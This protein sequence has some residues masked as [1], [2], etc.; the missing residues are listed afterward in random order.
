M[1]VAGGVHG[2]LDVAMATALEQGQVSL[3]RAR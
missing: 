3:T 1:T 2:L